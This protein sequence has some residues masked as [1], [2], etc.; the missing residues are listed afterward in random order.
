MTQRSETGTVTAVLGPT[1]T[2]KTHLA[3]ERMLGHRSGMIGL[4][5]RLLAREVYDKVAARA[6]A[7][8]VALITGEEKIKPPSP[9]YYVCTVEAMPLQADTEFVAVDEIQLAADAARGHVFTERMLNA[10]GSHE[11][12]L[13]GSATMKHAVRGLLPSANIVSRPRLSQLSYAGQKKVSRLPRRSA[14]V[15]FSASDV[16]AIAELV[17]RQRGGAAVVMGALSPKTRNAQVEIYQS[18]DV[19]FLVATDA[20]GMGLNLNVDHVAFAATRKFDGQNSRD[21][22]PAE[23]GQ[24]AGRAGRHM[25]DGSFGVTARADPLGSELVTT[26]EAHEFEPARLL[27][28]RSRN[29]DYTSVDALKSSL[30]QTPRSD[31]LVRARMVD[32]VI[33][34][35]NVSAEASVRRLAISPAAIRI[36]WDVCQ[37]PDY[38][39]IS[40]HA[41]AEMLGDIYAHV[42]SDSGHIPEDWFAAQVATSDRTDG[43]ID[44]LA[45]RIAHIRTWTFVSNRREWL[46]DPDHWQART[47]DIEDKLSDALHQ[48]LT[49]RFVDRRTSVLMKKLKNKDELFA[50]ISKDGEIHVEKHYVGQLKGFRF[51]PDSNS[52]DIHGKAA[53][54]AAAHVLSEELSQRAE[55]LL[56][57]EPGAFTLNRKGEIE[58]EGA[59]VARLEKGESALSPALILLADEHI[60]AADR[61]KVTE[62]LKT[63][64][65]THIAELLGPLVEMGNSKDI[66]GLARG[67]AFRLTET[68][69]ILR[70]EE[71]AEEIRALD[72]EARGQLRKFGV[73]FGAFN[74]YLPSLLKPAASDLI[75]LLWGI[76][77][78]E[79]SG[80]TPDN[81]PEPPRQGLTSAATD[82]S[83]PEA[84]YR[85]AGFHPCGKR[86]VRVDMLERLADMIRPLVAWRP[87]PENSTAPAGSTGK[88]GFRVQPDMMSI[89]GCSGDDFASVLQALGFRCE[90]K[91][92]SAAETTESSRNPAEDGPGTGSA[93]GEKDANAQTAAAEETSAVEQTDTQIPSSTPRDVAAPEGDTGADSSMATVMPASSAS[94]EP[95]FDEIWRPRRKKP[96]QHRDRVKGQGQSRDREARKGKSS[97]RRN[98]DRS[99]GRRP[100][101]DKAEQKGRAKNARPPRSVKK[102]KMPDPDSPFAALKDLKRDLENRVEDKA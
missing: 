27:Q 56:A 5:L 9:R 53:R 99:A 45:N 69:G 96:F 54:H 21:L 25:N 24:I 20:I 59:S 17:R 1:N 38:R 80:I 44:T 33:A 16:Y 18:G 36:L 78:G 98:E 15:A 57:A 73:R 84:I 87:T 34:L 66:T 61:E 46:A 39:K 4:P 101:R 88:G 12:L 97:H 100:P 23:M 11:T 65:K 30:Q 93:T 28:W 89:V 48:R 42:M 35:E 72:Q 10:R 77:S 47:R 55:R 8:N 37:I 26:L 22:T 3:I 32:D 94:A 58:W 85:L 90:R 41:H 49:L 13:L 64:A 68:L 74:I 102:E 6:G 81:M 63:W 19:D 79:Q 40:S 60:S 7:A 83:I 76:H 31:W 71:A 82:P 14:I 86:V 2:G 51:T 43:D 92:I 52:G 70:R 75:L 29:L 50:E 95:Q 91:P 67:I 62:H